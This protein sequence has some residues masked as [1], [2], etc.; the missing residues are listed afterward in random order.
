MAM[1]NGTLPEEDATFQLA[2]EL[3]DADREGVRHQ[4]HCE[5]V[6]VRS[7]RFISR[8]LMAGAALQQDNL[9]AGDLR[10]IIGAQSSDPNSRSRGRGLTEPNSRA[11]ALL[12]SIL[13]EGGTLSPA[14]WGTHRRFGDIEDFGEDGH[15]NAPEM[16]SL[17][18][19]VVGNTDLDAHERA[20]LAKRLDAMG[21]DV[22]V[23]RR[24]SASDPNGVSMSKRD[25]MSN[26]ISV[27]EGPPRTYRGLPIVSAARH[28]DDEVV[29]ALMELGADPFALV[30]RKSAYKV[31]P[32][33]SADCALD[34]NNSCATVI[35]SCLAREA[36]LAS[37]ET[38]DECHLPGPGV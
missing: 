4:L 27:P 21:C 10:E 25:S 8:H 5:Q 3:S 30:G 38:I 9:A 6:N 32:T 35:R 26:E 37:I 12:G 31:V 15:R 19:A 22:V 14:T 11:T 36:A 7:G 28:G 13:F 29:L 1:M 24:R 33:V 16:G 20:A 34:V 2:A 23:T 17:G 18:F